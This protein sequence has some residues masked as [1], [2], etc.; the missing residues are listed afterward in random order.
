MYDRESR[1]GATILELGNRIDVDEHVDVAYFEAATVLFHEDSTVV[2]VEEGRIFITYWYTCRYDYVKRNYKKRRVFD[3]YYE[4]LRYAGSIV[5]VDLTDLP[6]T[7]E[8]SDA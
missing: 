5:G 2:S 4:A 3:T 8:E 6:E 7:M 1:T